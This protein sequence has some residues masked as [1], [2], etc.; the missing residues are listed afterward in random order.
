VGPAVRRGLICLFAKAP[1]PGRVKTRI[2]RTL[3]DAQA[4]AL[5]RGFLMD[6]VATLRS[7]ARAD[8]VV[9]TP[10][11]VDPLGGV[12]AGLRCWD[13]GGGSLGD[14]L[15]R[16][17][18]RAL[19][20][21]P[22]ALAV[23][24]DSPGAPRALYRAAIGDLDGGA[25]AVLGSSTDGGFWLLGL[26]RLPAGLF[27]GVPWSSEA[28][29]AAMWDRL[30]GAGLAPRRGAPWFDVDEAPD[31]GRLRALLGASRI[32]APA[33]AAVLA[34]LNGPDVLGEAAGGLSVIVP[35]LNE[36]ERVGVLVER[37]RA[38]P[39]I[40]EILV[41]D[42]GSVDGTAIVAREAGATAVVTA[43]AGRARQMNAGARLAVGDVLAFVH[44]DV[45]PPTALSRH[46]RAALADPRAVGG[47][48][49]TWTVDEGG[50][51]WLG[52]LIHLA[53]VRSRLTRLP[54]GDQVL[55]VRR[56]DFEAVGGFPDQPLMEDLA[57]AL[58]LRARGRLARV[59]ARVTVSGRR[60]VR[61]PLRTTLIW[62]TFPLLYRLGVSPE[63]LARLYQHVR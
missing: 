4:A 57:I 19:A 6:T 56:H 10:G 60:L 50:D 3:G 7:L 33:S 62:N 59:P 48:F 30:V 55:F 37:L 43:P 52:P 22:W 1:V 46:V 35:T 51:S 25:E 41:V 39:G 42:G 63:R 12:V 44:A 61:S 34:R 26:R 9:A 32:A 2:A 54:Y 14:R 28:T 24:S 40:R 13:Q 23:G 5:A 31:L 17:L 58:R 45:T 38:D 16:V 21:A 18:A 49:V 8:L 36:A 53:D 27:E 11:G 29:G 20:E 47:A 15:H